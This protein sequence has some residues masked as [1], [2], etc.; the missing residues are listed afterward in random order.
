MDENFVKC[1][2]MDSYIRSLGLAKPFCFAQHLVQLSSR[3]ILQNQVHP[4]LVV[5]VTIQTKNIRVPL[6]SKFDDNHH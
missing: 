5:K 4:L 1:N 6:N 2:F 3:S